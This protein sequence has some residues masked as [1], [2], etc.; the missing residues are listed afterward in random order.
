MADSLTRHVPM[1]GWRIVYTPA[2][3]K[4]VCPFCG[5][6]RR[7]GLSR[8]R[9]APPPPPPPNERRGWGEGGGRAETPEPERNTCLGLGG[10][11]VPMRHVLAI[12]KK[13]RQHGSDTLVHQF[14]HRFNT[15]SPHPQHTFEIRATQLHRMANTCSNQ[16]HTCQIISKP[17]QLFFKQCILGYM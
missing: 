5:R 17:T 16:C 2:S 3:N 1:R 10:F 13:H 6:G 9:G 7:V 14:K 4:N 11:L 8:V 15:R 12:S